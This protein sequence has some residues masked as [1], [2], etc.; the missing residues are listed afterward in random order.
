M[1]VVTLEKLAMEVPDVDD[2]REI[3][4]WREIEDRVYYIEGWCE[5]CYA[6]TGLGSYETEKKINYARD[7]TPMILEKKAKERGL[8]LVEGRFIETP[9]KDFI[10]GVTMGAYKKQRQRSV[11]HVGYRVGEPQETDAK[12]LIE[13]E[14]VESGN[15]PM[16]DDLAAA[17]NCEPTLESIKTAIDRQFGADAIGM[18]LCDSPEWA[19]KRYGPGE[20]YEVRIPVDA[21]VGTDL[22]PDGKLWIWS[23]HSIIKRSESSETLKL[24]HGTS[25]QAA[26]KILA[27]GFRLPE[28]SSDF[29]YG[30]GLYF[31]KTIRGARMYGAVVLEVEIDVDPVEVPKMEAI[32][33]FEQWAKVECQELGNEDCCRLGDECFKRY[34]K[35]AEEERQN[36]LREGSRVIADATQ[37]VI[38]SEDMIRALKPKRVIREQKDLGP[39]VPEESPGFT[40]TLSSDEWRVLKRVCE[41]QLATKHLPAKARGWNL[42]GLARMAF[43]EWGWKEGKLYRVMSNLGNKG[44]VWVHTVKGE[45]G[46]FTYSPTAKGWRTYFKYMRATELP[47][48]EP[49]EEEAK[50]PWQEIFEPE[51]VKKEV[52]T[53]LAPPGVGVEPTV[54][55]EI[56]MLKDAPAIVGA[57]MKVYGP[58]KKGKVY[59]V[60]KDNARAFLKV[61]IAVATRKEAEKPTL[62]ELFKGEVLEPYIE[63]AKVK[64]LGER[65]YEVPGKGYMGSFTAASDEEAV[66]KQIVHNSRH[67]DSHICKR[68]T[69]EKY[70][71]EKGIEDPAAILG[72]LIRR[73]VVYVPREGYIG[74]T[75]PEKY[76]LPPITK[77]TGPETARLADYF[78]TKLEQAGVSL[79][80]RFK[81]EFEKALDLQKTYRQNLVIMDELINKIARGP[82]G[83]PLISKEEGADYVWTEKAPEVE[84]PKNIMWI[85]NPTYGSLQEKDLAKTLPEK[86]PWELSYVA[87]A[88]AL[89]ESEKK[90]LLETAKCGEYPGAFYLVAPPPPGTSD[91][92]LLKVVLRHFVD[93]HKLQIAD[94][95]KANEAGEKYPHKD[96]EGNERERIHLDFV[97]GPIVDIINENPDAKATTALYEFILQDTQAKWKGSARFRMASE[98]HARKLV[99]AVRS[100]ASYPT[101]K[102]KV[103]WI[104][105]P[106][107]ARDVTEV[108]KELLKRI[109][110]LK[111]E[112]MEEK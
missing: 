4:Y 110:G 9:D 97:P 33:T 80:S 23:Q 6:G 10:F 65:L 14:V 75:E 34:T 77:L 79:P 101:M 109:K 19:E 84:A 43:P 88:R 50:T 70:C 44:C 45:V 54:F 15:V 58:F 16:L 17:L 99:A 73:G 108:R 111:E 48:G 96:K 18:W 42:R 37:V 61:K 60:P 40:A 62:K 92:A 83:K 68:E 103:P 104:E 7:L 100:L 107:E 27:E 67:W 76:G 3:N 85:Y 1:P 106:P 69:L 36:R 105:A 26:E 66:I 47:V 90:A 24:Y 78:L 89:K 98:G 52:V 38:F 13:F 59:A 82:P 11:A 41:E 46:G 64:P 5:Q 81:G 22:G 25:K 72:D 63:A 55:V 21:M 94:Y 8:E 35:F 93:T 12:K 20:A 102:G 2:P 71:R 95:K 91:A 53:P 39:L 87:R 56:K 29:F 49:E 57:D 51:K 30:R 32:G 112:V 28:E 86:D 31:K 74:L